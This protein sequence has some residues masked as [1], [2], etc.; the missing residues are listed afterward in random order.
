MLL[1]QLCEDLKYTDFLYQKK[2]QAETATGLFAKRQVIAAKPQTFM[3]KSGQS[4]QAIMQY[5]KISQEDI[6]IIHDDIDL[7]MGKTKLKY[8]GSHGGHN[9]IRDTIRALGTQD[10]RRLK[11][12]VGRPAH[13]DHYVSDYVLGSF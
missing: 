5:Y 11:I 1:D 2:F 13:A 10:F 9:G 3:N 8:A 12:G 4:I 7:P 6:L